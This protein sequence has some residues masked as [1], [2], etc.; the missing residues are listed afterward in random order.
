MTE[1]TTD[2]RRDRLTDDMQAL[3]QRLRE[4]R[5]YLGLSQEAVAERLG[6]A[7]ATISAVEAGKRKVSSMELRDFAR[8]YRTTVEK[9]LGDTEEPDKDPVVGALFRTA[10]DLTHEDRKQVLRFAEFLR[11]AGTAPE[12]KRD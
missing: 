1:R 4:G 11:A 5:E 9:L 2:E 7:R 12:P 8:L 3:A 6:V 10:R